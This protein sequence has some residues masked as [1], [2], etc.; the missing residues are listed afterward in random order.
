[1]YKGINRGVIAHIHVPEFSEEVR[2]FLENC[3]KSEHILP[4]TLG[5]VL[6]YHAE[7]MGVASKTREIEIFYGKL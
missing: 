1:M 2:I 3:V 7:S 5:K 6:H 4:L